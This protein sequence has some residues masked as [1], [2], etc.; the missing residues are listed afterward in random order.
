VLAGVTRRTRLAVV[1]HVT[2]ATALV[3]PVRRIVGELADRGVDTLVD[4]AHAPGMVPLELRQLGAAWYTGNGHK[5]LCAPKGSGFLHVRRDRHAMTEPLVVS[6]GANSPRRDRSGL[7]LAFDWTGTAD[8][9]PL[10]ALP[11]A[12]ELLGSLSPDGWG[13]VM[14]ANR[15]LALEG[16][17]LIGEALGVASSGLPPA[18]LVGSMAAVPLPLSLSPVAALDAAGA[19]GD[20]VLVDAPPGLDTTR[21]EDPL[22]RDLYLRD[23]IQVPVYAWPASP[24]VPRTPLR[25][26]RISAQR[27]NSRAEYERLAAALTERL[28]G[29]A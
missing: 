13:G 10:L 25:L 9:T 3:L 14:R 28:D 20:G 23:R 24:A 11:A 5:W 27:Y 12:L 18:E 2:S 8:P 15:A 26:L 1:S 16:R 19:R 6:H 7:R 29:N 4:G 21:P 17:A 22:H